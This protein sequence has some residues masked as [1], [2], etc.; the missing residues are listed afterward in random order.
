M[1]TICFCKDHPGSAELRRTSAQEH[2]AYIESIL[3]R[4]L[5]A[6]PLGE[7]GS[8]DFDASCFIYDTDDRDEALQLLHNDPYYKAGIYADVHC[9]FF[10][11][12]AGAWIG[13]KIW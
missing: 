11:P 6:G 9:Q 13:G 7:N 8:D 12:A 3:H 5:I 2:L 1:A 10:L 4:I